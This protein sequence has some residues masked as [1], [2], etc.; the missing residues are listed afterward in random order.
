M[1]LR[2]SL[3]GVSAAA[4]QLLSGHWASTASTTGNFVLVFN[5]Q[6]PFETLSPYAKF[7]HPVLGCGHLAPA[8]GWVWV[9]LRSVSTLDTAGKLYTNADLHGE[10]MHNPVMAGAT[11]G[12]ELHWQ[13]TQSSLAAYTISTV[14]V[15][16]IDPQHSRVPQMI[17]QGLHM[18]SKRVKVVNAGDAPCM[19]QCRRCH[20]L[21][22]ATRSPLCKLHLAAVKCHRCGGPHLSQNHDYE[23]KGAHCTLGKCNCKPKCLLCGQVSHHC[24][25]RKCPKR[26]NFS[27][28]LEPPPDHEIPYVSSAT[29][30]AAP[31]AMPKEVPTQREPLMAQTL[32]QRVQSQ[33]AKKRVKAKAKKDAV[34]VAAST[35]TPAA[36]SNNRFV[37]LDTLER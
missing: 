8:D 18:F 4:P 30:E 19:I 3:E 31:V 10:I 36:P 14:L 37:A 28:T 5:R 9:H 15:P 23:C 32:P 27:S 17:S 24:Q 12:M 33:A 25:S 29:P 11:F 16:I 1:G 34:A 2:S 22:H 7:L 20:L 13:P 35:L 26:G 21:G 6:V